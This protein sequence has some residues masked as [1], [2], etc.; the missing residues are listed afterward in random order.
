MN[1]RIHTYKQLVPTW[2]I[3]RERRG[4][5]NMFDYKI[6]RFKEGQFQIQKRNRLYFNYLKIVISACNLTTKKCSI[7]LFLVT[8]LLIS[9]MN[10]LLD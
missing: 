1:K 4:L 3:N 10:T 8:N 5:I 2:R 7:K 6:F 9:K